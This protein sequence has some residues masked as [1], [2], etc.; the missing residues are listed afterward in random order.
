M[1]STEVING[2]MTAIENQQWEQADR[3]IGD[4]FTFSGAI[5]KPVGK[6]EWLSLHKA[7]ETGVPDFK[8]NLH[9]VK[10]E[11]G[12][13]KA[14]VRITGTHSR[15]IPGPIPG[16]TMQNKILASGKKVNM[17]VEECEFEVK[18]DKLTRLYVKP[19]AGG[20]VPGFMEQIGQK[21]PSL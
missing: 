8:F 19:V 12:K 2:L 4:E 5:P 1:K 20:G 13:V 16:I 7:L 21:L 18:N 9:D 15:D 10:E 17:P 11:D 6:K 14:K 3:Y